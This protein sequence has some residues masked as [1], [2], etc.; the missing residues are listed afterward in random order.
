MTNAK[1]FQA[2]INRTFSSR[3]GVLWQ[4]IQDNQLCTFLMKATEKF[5]ADP[6]ENKTKKAALVIGKQEKTDAGMATYV[7]NEKVQV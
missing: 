2:A 3:G 6:A 4:G 7:L 5:W 1:K